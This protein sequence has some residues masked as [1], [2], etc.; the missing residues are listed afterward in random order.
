MSRRLPDNPQMV[1]ALDSYR[2]PET[3]GWEYGWVGLEPT[4]QSRKSIRKWREMAR[5]EAG[6]VAYFGDK[7]MLRKQLEVARAMRTAGA[8]AFLAKSGN[9][10]DVV[11][12]IRASVWSKRR[13]RKQEPQR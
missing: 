4:F 12:A 8:V 2:L 7:Y 1:S 10:Q 13:P 3:T 11:D 6:E 5:T 9:V